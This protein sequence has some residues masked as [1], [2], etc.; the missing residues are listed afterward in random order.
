MLKWAVPLNFQR[1]LDVLLDVF[2]KKVTI[3]K[4]KLAQTDEQIFFRTRCTTKKMLKD[5]YPFDMRMFKLI[6]ASSSQ[7]EEGKEADEKSKKDKEGAQKRHDILKHFYLTQLTQFPKTPA[8]PGMEPKLYRQ[9]TVHFFEEVTLNQM[10]LYF[11]Q[12]SA[13]FSLRVTV[14]DKKTKKVVYHKAYPPH[15]F[16]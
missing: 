8:K 4:V 13:Q 9:F 11:A 10:K 3:E 5:I 14:T 15:M 7:N 12:T 6:D 2:Y 1:T 16:V